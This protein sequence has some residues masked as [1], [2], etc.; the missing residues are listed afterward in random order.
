M[1]YDVTEQDLSMPL[2]S[3]PARPANGFMLT[4]VRRRG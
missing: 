2:S 1:S 4:N 3:T